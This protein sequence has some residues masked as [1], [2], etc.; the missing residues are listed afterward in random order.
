M[1]QRDYY[2]I[3]GVE[4]S[5]SAAEIKNAYRK[6]AIKFHPD[7]APGDKEAE[8]K[9][10]EAAGA[11][12]ILSD[13]KKRAIYDQYGHQGIAGGGFQDVSDIFSSFGSIFEDFFGG[14]TRSNTRSRGYDL[15]HD[16]EI[17]FEQAIFGTTK[18][19][20]VKKDVVCPKCNGLGAE[21][22][23][24]IV[25]CPQCGGTGQMRISQGFFT[26][27][28]TCSM[29]KGKGTIIKKPCSMCH[30]KTTIEK[31]E[32]INVKI[33]AG[34]EDGIKLR[35]S[36]KGQP[37]TNGGENGDLYVFIGV[38]PSEKYIR[39]GSTITLPLA[40][41]MTEAALGA[42]I[43]IETLEG[44]ETI[45]IPPATQFGHQIKLPHKGVPF[46]R[47][48]GRGDFIVLIQVLIPE[49]LNKKQKDLLIEFDQ[50][51][52][53]NNECSRSRKLKSNEKTLLGRIFD[54]GS[55]FKN[56]M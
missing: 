56:K 23:S 33:P 42:E 3:L 45:K 54:Q 18:D 34:V 35:L 22:Q 16:L 13:K 52:N 21:K 25:T 15:R 50:S 31:N 1:S 9:F 30:G 28:T 40:V 6:A 24:D 47:G 36:N 12:E 43:E 55:K 27:Q 39:E 48:N 29:C 46:L 8:D 17:T 41:S 51:S 14:R 20:T 44:S 37:S 26:L 32:S 5:A 53:T 38:S 19:I 49:K 4:K 11:Y 7:R 10:K 2:E